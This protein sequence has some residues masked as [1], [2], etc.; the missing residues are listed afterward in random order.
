MS[1]PGI[2]FTAYPPLPAVDDPE[3]AL[4]SLWAFVEG[5]GIDPQEVVDAYAH[6]DAF[7]L[8][9]AVGTVRRALSESAPVEARKIFHIKP[10]DDGSGGA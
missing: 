2:V 1:A 6:Q 3:Q 4:S 8:G 10:P 9:H 7:W 5:I